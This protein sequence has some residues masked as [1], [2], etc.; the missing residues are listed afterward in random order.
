[1]LVRL[2]LQMS[3]YQQPKIR[4]KYNYWQLCLTKDYDK[5]IVTKRN[6]CTYIMNVLQE[7]LKKEKNPGRMEFVLY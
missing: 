4:M 5:C 2:A 7:L 1:M 3:L 6:T